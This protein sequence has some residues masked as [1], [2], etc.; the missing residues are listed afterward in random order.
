[1]TAKDFTTHEENWRILPIPIQYDSATA[2]DYHNIPIDLCSKEAEEPL[3][4][5]SEYGLASANYYARS[6]GLNSP[7]YKKFASALEQI[8]LRKTVV[9]KLARVN[10]KLAA[11]RVE[12]LVLDGYR[13]IAL[14]NELWNHF[15]QQ[16]KIAMD[17]PSEEDCLQFAG[18]YCSDPRSYDENDFRTWPTHNTGGA[19]DLTLRSIETKEPLFFGGIFDDASEISSSDY[20]ERIKENRLSS[21]FIE[22][23]RN[24]RLL[25]W[26]ML[27]EGFANFPYE[28]WHFDFGT[29]MWVMNSQQTKESAVYG[30]ADAPRA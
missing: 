20:F 12:L 28:W 4:E 8:W 10:K 14:Q 22:A 21:S 15:I 3:I 13:P 25:Y 17:N 9:E 26:S 27:S 19:V 11:Y 6:D 5:I 16:A 7:Y 24:R 2:L 18:L 23:K 29:Q 30:R 1:M